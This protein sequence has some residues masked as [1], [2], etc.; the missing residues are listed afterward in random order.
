HLGAEIE[1]VV[2][3]RILSVEKRPNAER[4][5]VCRV[6]V[7]G[8][9]VQVVTGARN[10]EPGALVPIALDGARLPGGKTISSGRLRGVES[11][12]MLCSLSELG[13]DAHDFPYA[14]ED[15]IFL[16]REDCS[17]GDDIR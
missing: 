11:E 12:G 6:D 14:Q 15:G 2:V 3:G 1:N 8:R 7:G 4:L 17:P 10:V 16:L 13:L 9:V 5:L